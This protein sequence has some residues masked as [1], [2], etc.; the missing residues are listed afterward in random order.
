MLWKRRTCS[1]FLAVTATASTFALTL[2]DAPDARA[3]DDD[4]QSNLELADGS[5]DCDELREKNSRELAAW[6]KEQPA[7]PYR[8]PREST[9]LNA[10]WGNFIKSVGHSGELILATLIPH[11]GAQ[12][13]ADAPAAH[14]SWPW[15]VLV[16]GPY[17]ACSRKRGTFVVHGHRV[18]RF[19]VEPAIVSSRVGVGFSVRP[20]YRF[21]WHPTSWVVGPGLGLGS[22][23][24]IAGAKEPFRY[25][26]G[27]ELVAHFGRCCS[28]SYF[29]FALRYDH[30]FK[31]NSRDII[32]GSLGYT[33]F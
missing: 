23:V 19:L 28:S 18:H 1:R 25:S 7:V 13:R 11:V 22:T 16:I 6:E 4:A 10:P 24:E 2:V 31:G 17:Y 20:G 12:Y 15:S 30:Y 33:F 9:V 27:P 21:I 8:Y 26:V 29:T 32:G 5:T 3:A 14:V